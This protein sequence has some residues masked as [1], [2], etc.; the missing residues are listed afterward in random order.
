MGK[1]VTLSE[2]AAKTGVSIVTV[3]KALSGQKGVSEATRKQICKVAQEM[4]RTDG[5]S[6]GLRRKVNY[7][8]GVV[9]AARYFTDHLS[10]YWAVYRDLSVR[11]SQKNCFC[12][13]EIV[14]EEEE[15]RHALPG[16]WRGR[17]WTGCLS[18]APWILCMSGIWSRR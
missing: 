16:V 2:I 7:T 11:L 6:G 1:N 4:G 8:I 17:A 9:A 14:P 10:M 12:L 3:S 5:A 15:D 18:S 13:L